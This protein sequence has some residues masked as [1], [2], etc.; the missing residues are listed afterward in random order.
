MSKLKN[1]VAVITG[2]NSGIGLATAK[3]F[4][5]EGAKVVISGRRPE[6]LEIL[7]SELTG[8]FITV[9]ADVSKDEDNINLIKTTVD[10]YGKIDVLFLNAGIAPPTPTDAVTADHYY[11]IFDINVKGPMLAVKEAL[12]HINDGGTIIFTSSIVHQKGFE[13]LSVYSASKGALRAYARV[14]TEEVK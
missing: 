1:K 6:A 13:G 5:S 14:L 12:P 7:K 8:E 3:L 2:A 11:E 10:T 4:L 9:V